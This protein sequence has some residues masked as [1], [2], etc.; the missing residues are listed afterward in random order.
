MSG[1][2]TWSDPTRRCGG[3]PAAAALTACLL[4]ACSGTPEMR[5]PTAAPAPTKVEPLGVARGF[6]DISLFYPPEERRQG[7]QGIVVVHVCPDEAGRLTE[8][9]TIETSSGNADLDAAGLALANA[10]NGFYRPASRA[11]IPEPGCGK[12]GLHF[13]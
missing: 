7:I 10:G 4:A 5:V 1:S 12:L 3:S 11:G 2:Q 9:P 6:P 13:R 8:P